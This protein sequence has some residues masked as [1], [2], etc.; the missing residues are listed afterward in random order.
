M[1]AGVT[2]PGLVVLGLVLAGGLVGLWLARVAWRHGDDVAGA[3]VYALLVG[4]EGMWCLSYLGILLSTPAVAR[5]WFDPLVT[6]FAVLAPFLWLLFTV[7]YTGRDHWVTRRTVALLFVEPAV[8]YALYVTNPWHH[9]LFTE[10]QQPVAWAGL[11]LLEPN[12]TGPVWVQIAFLYAVTLAGIVLLADYVMRTRNVYRRQTAAILVGSLLTV[13][14]NVIYVSGSSPT[15]ALDVTPLFF[16]ANGVVIA[17][18]LF[19]YDFL[20]VAPVARDV[21]VE[22]MDDPVVVVDG[23]DTL[24]NYNPA[25]TRILGVDD[26]DVG[27]DV[28]QCLQGLV[29]A[30]DAEGAVSLETV[31]G[32]AAIYDP[33]PT[34]LTD[35]QGIERGRLVV[36]RE[37]TLL[38]RREQN[39]AALQSAT[40][41]LMQTE[42]TETVVAIVVATAADVLDHQFAGFLA[43]DE[44]RERL[45]STT[46]TPAVARQIPGGEMAYGPGDGMVWDAFESGKMVV[47]DEIDKDD[48]VPYADLPLAS[49]VLLPMGEHG[50]LGV[51]SM[52]PRAYSDEE[53]RFLRI[54]ASAAESALD[55][56]SREREMREHREA[57]EERNERLENFAS[58]VSHDLRTPLT[59][60]TGYLALARQDMADPDGY[61]E[62]VADSHER[63]DSLVEDLLALARQGQ[64]VD[65]P[66]P[67]P[68]EEVALNAWQTAG[69]VDAEFDLQE[70]PSEIVAD[71]ERVRTLLENLL[72]NAV[73]HG[74]TS[75]RQSEDAVAHE[76]T[77]SRPEADDAGGMVT[78]RVGPVSTAAGDGADE[79]E[80]T[81]GEVETSG[82]E[83][84]TASA[85]D[86]GATTDTGEAIADGD[87]A[88]GFYV[89]DD[90]PGI[91]PGERD[92]VLEQGYSGDTGTGL[93][94]AIVDRIADAHGWAVTITD[95]IDGGARFE[96]TGVEPAD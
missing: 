12:I 26:D 78:V 93:G 87:G 62:R 61:L 21:V 30:L 13:V 3:R 59:T 65:D 63:M 95:G 79:A 16:L 81:S 44:E 92:E 58:I 45:E 37:V 67:V 46:L 19:Q 83:T 9:W 89:E 84:E 94:L 74:S 54:L 76:A 77:G 32:E 72:G 64:V 2:L 8:Y 75:S 11:T 82:G 38:K 41:E 73:E 60:A 90:G 20:S 66:E 55:R 22:E 6:V 91:P 52:E 48:D 43:Y 40:R 34:A 86:D 49:A 14:G 42:R 10:P 7:Q 25:A 31:D 53:V 33:R 1:V 56:I 47:E 15:R 71:R 28:E 96:F 23:D 39:L 36:L 80:G 29:A 4:V 50:L 24:V 17:W 70:F 18:A 85:V 5:D 51:G 69:H 57:L 68:L 35:Q 27:H 88:V